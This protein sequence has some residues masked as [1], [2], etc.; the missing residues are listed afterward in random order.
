MQP[1]IKLRRLSSDRIPSNA[2]PDIEILPQGGSER[3][4][5]DTPD[6]PDAGLLS[7][8]SQAGPMSLSPCPGSYDHMNTSTSGDLNGQ[9]PASASQC[10]ALSDVAVVSRTGSWEGGRTSSSGRGSASTVGELQASSRP[11]SALEAV[12]DA[13]SVLYHNNGG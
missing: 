9:A 4:S 13:Y 2:S 1:V 3:D 11:P 10:V 5:P 8:G 12:S 7:E 6:M